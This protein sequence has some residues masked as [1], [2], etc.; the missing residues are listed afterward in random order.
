MGGR[1][2]LTVACRSP[3]RQVMLQA[4]PMLGPVFTTRKR[5]RGLAVGIAASTFW[6]AAQVG[7]SGNT[8]IFLAEHESFGIPVLAIS[9]GDVPN[10]WPG[11]RNEAVASPFES[12]RL[13]PFL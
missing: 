7:L 9:C 1:K 8:I 11:D 3:F 2:A 12:E 6:R 5:R 13:T 4:L 10:R